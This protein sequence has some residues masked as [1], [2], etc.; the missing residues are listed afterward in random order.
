MTTFRSRPKCRISV[1]TTN[2]VDVNEAMLL[3][4]GLSARTEREDILPRALRALSQRVLS[5]SHK[6]ADK[7]WVSIWPVML[8]NGVGAAAPLEF[9]NALA[10]AGFARGLNVG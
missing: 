4:K 3:G 6:E 1:A 2:T 7:Q 5:P 9:P 8:G 10:P